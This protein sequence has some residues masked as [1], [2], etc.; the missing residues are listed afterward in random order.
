[1]VL[2]VWHPVLPLSFLYFAYPAWLAVCPGKSRVY[3]RE[4][5]SAAKP[6][7]GN[8]D[9]DFLVYSCLNLDPVYSSLPLIYI[10]FMVGSVKLN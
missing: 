10:I 9:S 4:L 2:A 7:G 6:V 8:P 1:M 3:C 5:G